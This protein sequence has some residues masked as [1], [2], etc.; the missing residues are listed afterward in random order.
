MLRLQKG[1]ACRR[2]LDKVR[3]IE[4]T[5]LWVQEKVQK[6]EIEIEKVKTE[7]NL[8]GAMTKYVGSAN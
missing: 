6:K 8:A 1:I 3:H 4:A 7:E 5:Q 2:G